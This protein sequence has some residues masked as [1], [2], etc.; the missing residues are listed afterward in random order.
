MA[1]SLEPVSD[2]ASPS[3]SAPPPLTLCLSVS[4]KC[5]NVKKNLK[6]SSGEKEVGGK[7]KGEGGREREDRERERGGGVYKSHRPSPGLASVPVGV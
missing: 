2:S 4:Q 1:Q 7:D 6:R 5:I 3:L